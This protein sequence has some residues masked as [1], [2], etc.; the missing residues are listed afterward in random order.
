MPRENKREP[1]MQAAE[2]LFSSRR[3]HEITLDDIAREASVGKGTIY[4]YFKDKDD[5]FFQ[6]AVSG[7]EELCG[8]LE[9]KVAGDAPF[10]D[11]LSQACS[12]MSAFFGRRR[13]LMC[14]LQAEDAR[15]SLSRGRMRD[16]WAEKRRL[17]VESL[18]DIL[19][20]GQEE[21]MVR[22]DLPAVA[23][24]EFLLGLLRT[25]A[26]NLTEEGL[27]VGDAQVADLFLNGSGG[28]AWN[29]SSFVRE[30]T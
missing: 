18:A 1:I 5:L 19:A 24:A 25:R 2:K 26:R 12:A 9:L 6:V 17:L 3:F 28:L 21:G 20:R 8:L 4:R 7:F 22:T 13:Q 15:M 29:P 16:R 30:K 27:S 23:L 14:M 10:P 11:Q